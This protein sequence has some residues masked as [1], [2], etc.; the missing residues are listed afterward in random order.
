MLDKSLGVLT[1]LLSTIPQVVGIGLGGSASRGANTLDSDVDVFVLSTSTARWRVMR[2]IRQAV[3]DRFPVAYHVDRGFSAGMGYLQQFLLNDASTIDI[4]VIEENRPEDFDIQPT[5]LVLFDSRDRLSHLVRNARRFDDISE[6]RA[7]ELIASYTALFY[8]YGFGLLKSLQKGDMWRTLYTV[9]RMR[10]VLFVLIRLSLRTYSPFLRR[11]ED[12]IERV[13]PKNLIEMLAKYKS[14]PDWCTLA[15]TAIL[16]LDTL[17]T[18]QA[19]SEKS[20]L[21]ERLHAE[22]TRLIAD[23]C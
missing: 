5:M 4:A 8:I 23:T 17:R 7:D 21:E 19:T 1:E 11:P 20:P 3:C 12:K 9:E 6:L 10:N 13:L 16:L 14:E 15:K 2:D 22:F 18:M